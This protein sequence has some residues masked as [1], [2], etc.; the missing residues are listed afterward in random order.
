MALHIKCWKFFPVLDIKSLSKVKSHLTSSI[1]PDSLARWTTL[2]KRNQVV[3]FNPDTHLTRNLNNLNTCLNM[4]QKKLDPCIQIKTTK[5]KLIR[6][7]RYQQSASYLL[8]RK[9]KDYEILVA[10]FFCL[11]L[12]L[13]V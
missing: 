7:Q 12:N 2:Y 13:P 11:E 3:V 8:V 9:K 4:S 5:F 10:A 6:L 1:S